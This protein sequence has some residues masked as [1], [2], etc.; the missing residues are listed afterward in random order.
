MLGV[1]TGNSFTLT[2]QLKRSE[3]HRHKPTPPLPKRDEAPGSESM[4][5]P[6]GKNDQSFKW[7]S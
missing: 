4:L 7:F 3:G 6:K 2:L 1:A 5:F